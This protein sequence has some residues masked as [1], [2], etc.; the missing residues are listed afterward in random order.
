MKRPSLALGAL[1]GGL[2]GLPLIALWYLG[3]QAAGLV[4]MRHNGEHRHI[5]AQIGYFHRLESIAHHITERILLE[6][7]RHSDG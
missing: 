2:T 1:L 7:H 5:A 3:Q 6:H 4:F